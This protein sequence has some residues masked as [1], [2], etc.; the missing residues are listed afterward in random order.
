MKLVKQV[1]ASL[2]LNVSQAL[3]EASGFLGD[4][5]HP[6]IAFEREEGRGREGLGVW[7]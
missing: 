2:K 6:L 1:S 4:L 7:D 3:A 5:E